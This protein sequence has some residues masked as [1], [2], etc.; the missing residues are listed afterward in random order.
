MDERDLR[1]TQLAE[2]L[3]ITQG[4]VSR[5]LGGQTAFS[6]ADGAAAG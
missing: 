4:N 1:Q 3:G 2:V 5:L 6:V